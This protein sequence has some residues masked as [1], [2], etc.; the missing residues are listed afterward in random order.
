MVRHKYWE[1]NSRVGVVT[2]SFIG[3]EYRIHDQRIRLAGESNNLKGFVDKS[4]VID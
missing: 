1:M 3:S 2:P 4:G